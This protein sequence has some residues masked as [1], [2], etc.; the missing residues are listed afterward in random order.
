MRPESFAV[1]IALHVAALGS[2]VLLLHVAGRGAFQPPQLIATN[3]LEPRK[4]TKLYAPA[5]V[6]RKEAPSH[7]N[8]GGGSLSPLPVRKGEPRAFRPPVAAPRESKMVMPMVFEDAPKIALGGDPNGR[9]GVTGAGPGLWGFGGPGNGG[10]PRPGP[11][12]GGHGGPGG[13]G[14]GVVARPSRWPQLVQK[15]EPEYSEP[16]RKARFQGSVLLACDVGTDGRPRN[17]RV[18]RGLGMGL[19]EK[20]MDAVSTWKFRPALLNGRPVAAPITV[21]VNF[22]LL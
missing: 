5:P 2:I 11:G 13:E 17:I 15:I 4:I 8:P 14:D 1:S 19:D 18:V 7:G 21:E 6:S 10:V 3:T 16:A 20:A 9:V 12:P 22:R